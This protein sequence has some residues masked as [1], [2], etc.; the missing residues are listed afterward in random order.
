MEDQY[1]FG[2]WRF[3]YVENAI[4]TECTFGSATY[5][6]KIILN[7]IEQLIQLKYKS[8]VSYKRERNFE[9]VNGNTNQLQV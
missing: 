5:Y 1:F 3:T 7:Y 2:E 9:E 6:K 8:E 4:C